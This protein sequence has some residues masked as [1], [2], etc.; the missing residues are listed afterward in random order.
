MHFL[1]KATAMI[2]SIGAEIQ[3]IMI[4]Y[5]NNLPHRINGK[6]RA[7]GSVIF[8][9]SSHGRHHKDSDI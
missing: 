6:G 2:F 4:H 9:I 5:Y 1:G 8:Y 3:R 7:G